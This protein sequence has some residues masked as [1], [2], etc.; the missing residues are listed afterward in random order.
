MTHIIIIII[1]TS[2]LSL[3]TAFLYSRQNISLR[4]S[5]K[6]ISS[7]GYVFIG[8][9]SLIFNHDISILYASG[10]LLGLVFGLMGDMLLSLHPYLDSREGIQF[11]LAG[12]VCFILGHVM[13]IIVFTIYV[14]FNTAHLPFLLILPLIMFILI[15]IKFINAGKYSFTLIVYCA[16]FNL[17]LVQ[18][19]YYHNIV[20]N[21]FS[22]MLLTAVV[23]FIISDFL[24][25]LN[26]FTRKKCRYLMSFCLVF[27]Y[28]AQIIFATS[29][30]VM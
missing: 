8:I 2:L 13:Y 7:T 3:I 5:F 1:I 26:N 9:F 16:I 20:R 18:G 22:S 4:V 10:I 6:A 19:I 11:N 21:F 24:L 29:L 23:L 27:Y 12:M 14:G 17:M 15:K 30:M 28:S 25:A